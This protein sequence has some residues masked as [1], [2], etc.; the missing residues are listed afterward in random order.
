MNSD[1]EGSH[2]PNLELAQAE[3]EFEAHFKANNQ[4]ASADNILGMIREESMAPYYKTFC[5]KFS[6]DFDEQ[7]FDEMRSQ[8]EKNL[9]S[10][11]TK[12]EDSIE[13]GGDMEILDALFD[14]AKHFSSIGEFPLALKTYD[15]VI[16]REKTSTARKIDAWMAKGRIALFELNMISLKDC[17]V[18]SKRLVDIGGDWDRRNRLKVYEALYLIVRRD[19]RGAATLLL[20]CVATFSCNE[21]CSYKVFMF[22][23]VITNIMALSRT[24]LEK[25]VVRNPQVVSVLRYDLPSNNHLRKPI[26]RV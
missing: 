14:K 17:I 21:L 23:A 1:E 25:K 7:L 24:D 19:I 6:L 10:I 12:L 18:E 5:M 11:E 2:F 22:Y 3:F 9:A 13:R 26:R 15:E 8:N 16:H 20:D 4:K